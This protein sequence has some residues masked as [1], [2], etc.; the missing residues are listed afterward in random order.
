MFLTGYN[1]GDA[2]FEMAEPS[3]GVWT[4]KAAE[5]ALQANIALLYGYPEKFDAG[6]YNSTILIDRHANILA[7]YRK[8]HLFGPAENRLF[9]A[10][11]SLVL[12][13][14]EELTIGILICYDVEF[15]EAVRALTKAGAQLIAVPTAL[16]KPYCRIAKTVVPARAYESQVFVAYVNRIGSEKNMSFC[17]LSAIIGLDGYPLLE[18]GSDEEGVFLT[19]IEPSVIAAVR[20]E[21]PVLEDRRP[22]LYS[23]PILKIQKF[24]LYK[25]F[26]LM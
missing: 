7:D 14:L 16:M 20:K 8:T 25:L 5:I 1:I 12:T 4:Q 10:G 24:I 11:K 3:D 21:N 6:V 18:G 15:P 26:Q 2:V 9:Q 19:N 13:R 17:G 22:E 23:A